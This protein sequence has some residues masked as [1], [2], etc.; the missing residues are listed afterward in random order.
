MFKSG[1]SAGGTRG[2]VIEPSYRREMEAP[3]NLTAWHQHSFCLSNIAG[4]GWNHK[5]IYRIYRKLELNL[6]TRPKWRIKRDKPNA[7]SLPVA[8]SQ[9]WSVDFMDDLRVDGRLLRIFNMLDDYNREELAIK[10]DL[11]LP[12]DRVIRSLER[13]L[14][15]EVRLLALSISN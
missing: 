14:N 9:A 6:R 10:V 12:N 1:D 4:Y 8:P 13:L 11:S 2:K 7:L 15:G 5:R 3:A